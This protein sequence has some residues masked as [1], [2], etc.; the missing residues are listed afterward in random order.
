MT[1]KKAIDISLCPDCSNPRL[2]PHQESIIMTDKKAIDISLCPDCSNPMPE[3]KDCLSD[4]AVRVNMSWSEK[5][6][7]DEKERVS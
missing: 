1:D 6:C 4:G 5:S 2:V 3:Y 7:C